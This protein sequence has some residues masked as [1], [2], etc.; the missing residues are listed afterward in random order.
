MAELEK[1]PDAFEQLTADFADLSE[2]LTAAEA[3]APPRP[4][5]WLAPT[6]SA[7]RDEAIR[8]AAAVLADLAGW[9][10][11]VY[12]RY[13]DGATG[14]PECW[15]WHPDAV[16]E[17]LWL[18]TAWAVAYT[19]RSAS[20]LQVGDWHDRSRPGVARRIRAAVGTC[21]LENHTGTVLAVAAAAPKSRIAA[22]AAWW[23]LDRDGAPP[24]AD[25]RSGTVAG[26]LS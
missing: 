15:L 3:A 25:P 1:L 2:R 13:P 12:L 7:E 19:G 14:L 10:Q 24:A 4:T 5:S 8:K 20:A 17:L 23:A 21:S 6:E 22:V 11:A 9:V 26:R 16:E 18:R